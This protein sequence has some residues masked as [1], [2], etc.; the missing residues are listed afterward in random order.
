MLG[1]IVACK[2]R[3]E[4]SSTIE[5]LLTCKQSDGDYESSATCPKLGKDKCQDQEIY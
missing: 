1:N 2:L 4:G 3:R 5:K